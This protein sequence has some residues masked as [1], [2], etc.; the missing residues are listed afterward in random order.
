MVKGPD[1]DVAMTLPEKKRLF[2][3]LPPSVVSGLDRAG[4]ALG[5]KIIWEGN[6]KSEKAGYLSTLGCTA[7]LGLFLVLGSGLESDC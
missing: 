6:L 1:V 5:R 2:V 4:F 3:I 7:D